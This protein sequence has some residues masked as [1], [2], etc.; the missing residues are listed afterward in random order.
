MRFF[1][2]PAVLSLALLSLPAFSA[3]VWV[4]GSAVALQSAG[5]VQLA[6]PASGRT[7][8]S[9]DQPTYFPAIFNCRAQAGG[10]VLLQLSNQLRLAF[11]GE[12]FFSVERAESLLAEDPVAAARM[13]T[14]RDRMILNLRRGQL[15]IDSRKLP[16]A[17]KLVL[18]TPFGRISGVNIVLLV[19]IEF[20]YRSG[21]YDFTV[22][23]VEGVARLQDRRGLSYEI[24]PGQR[25]SGAGSYLS[26]AI[27]VGEQ[28]ND[29]RETFQA[30]FKV[31]EALDP[32]RVDTQQLQAQLEVLALTEHSATASR[33][34]PEGA[35]SPGNKRPRVIEYAPAA[36]PVT[37]FRAEVKPPSALQADLF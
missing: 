10:S 12:G 3:E 18:E 36:A 15:I 30:Y 32:A 26:P 6:V 2:I 4:R 33:L 8:Q 21:I 17:S 29:I 23:S 25:L 31:L 14:A 27:E 22:S 34:S 16:A 19:R 28:M 20:D 5:D 37:P 13:E 35:G 9:F 1:T 7:Y 11:R 24:Y